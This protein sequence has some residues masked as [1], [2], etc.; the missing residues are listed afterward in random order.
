MKKYIVT[1]ERTFGTENV[2]GI[3]IDT[4]YYIIDKYYEKATSFKLGGKT[5]LLDSLKEFI[6]HEFADEQQFDLFL[7]KSKKHPK[8]GVNGKR[9]FS[10]DQIEEYGTDVTIN[11]LTLDREYGKDR[12]LSQSEN[13]I[14]EGIEELKKRLSNLELG[15]QIIYDDVSDELDEVKGLIGKISDKNIKQ[16]II[17]KLVDAGLG[18]LAD[19]V[20]DVIS[21]IKLIEL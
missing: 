12:P 19:K 9:Y 14:L 4:L 13:L 2:V 1:L 6:I 20:I 10:L 15:Q 11:F 8:Q 21:G 18:K 7:E 16:L 5:F 3:N 17:G